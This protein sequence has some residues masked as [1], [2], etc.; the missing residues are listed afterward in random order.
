MRCNTRLL[1]PRKWKSQKLIHF[2]H[3]QS[4]KN[5]IRFFFGTEEVLL[6]KEVLISLLVKV[7]IT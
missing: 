3:R 4:Q 1:F 7:R 2:Q 5:G 6:K